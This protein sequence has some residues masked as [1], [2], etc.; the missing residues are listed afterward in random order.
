VWN[1]YSQQLLYTVDLSGY[2]DEL[3]FS[4]DGQKVVAACAGNVT[5]YDLYGGVWFSYTAPNTVSTAKYYAEYDLLLLG[6][7]FKPLVIYPGSGAAFEL[8]FDNSSYYVGDIELSADG[9]RVY[10]AW[11]YNLYGY[12]LVSSSL[13][14]EFVNY[15]SNVLSELAV[16]DSE[17]LLAVGDEMGNISLID[18]QNLSL[19]NDLRWHTNYIYFLDFAVSDQILFSAGYDGQQIVWSLQ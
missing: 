14:M 8:P 16:N 18:I 5:I 9:N 10:M 4:S 13:F 11:G 19:V 15:F 1:I 7:Y 6:G 17:T 12:D 3:R 2:P